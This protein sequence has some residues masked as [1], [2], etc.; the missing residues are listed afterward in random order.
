MDILKQAQTLSDELKEIYQQLHQNPE[1][2]FELE[3]TIGIITSYLDKINVKYHTDGKFILCEM[4]KNEGE[5]FLLRADMDALPISEE[6]GLP[7]ASQNG[8]CHA[9][10]HD[11]HATMLLGAVKL[12]KDADLKGK[13]LCLFQPAEEI[14]Q[15]AKYV[16]DKGVLDN[17]TAGMM[18][19]TMTAMP[20]ETGTVIV[21]S[22]GES[23]PSADYFTIKIKGKGGHGSSPHLCT[24]PI[25][26]SAN[27]ITSLQAL[28][29]RE[30]PQNKPF[31]LTF[32]EIHG[33]EAHNI[34]PDHVTLKGTFRTFDE[35]I[36]QTVR[37]RLCEISQSVSETFKATSEV[38]FDSGCPTLLNDKN[39][40][41]CVHKTLVNLLGKD[42]VF[43]SDEVN[44]NS[45]LGAGS[46]DFSYISHKIPTVM[47]AISAGKNAD[48]F[49]YP[50]HNPKVKFDQNAIPFG[51]AVYTASAIE[52]LNK[53]GGV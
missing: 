8:N 42:K 49:S 10:G 5:T 41:E 37:T 22:A 2:G 25:L 45:S 38:T 35:N 17:V 33:G 36:R 47:V 53:K 30:I 46:E 40:S 43:T 23:A 7:Y 11:M 48:G 14:L 32:G 12:L 50:L 20:F 27:L 4:G 24:D 19:H 16:L 51:T 13:V 44:K 21:S 39:V 18:L 26:A 31:V 15:G 34:I 1:L 28:N 3:K 29:S 52:Y 6:S 9:C